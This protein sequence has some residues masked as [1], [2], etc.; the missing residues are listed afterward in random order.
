MQYITEATRFVTR[1]DALGLFAQLADPTQKCLGF[2]SLR[3]LGC[4]SVYLMDNDIFLLVFPDGRGRT[5]TCD[6][7]NLSPIQG[8]AAGGEELKNTSA[9]RVLD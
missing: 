6:P 1:D 5:R 4:L 9:I 8:S 3:R 7:G 2:K